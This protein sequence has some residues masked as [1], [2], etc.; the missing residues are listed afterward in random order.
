MPCQDDF[1]LSN[2][3]PSQDFV[4]IRKRLN[5][6]TRLLCYLC[7]EIEFAS[8]WSRYDRPALRKWWDRH[9]KRDEDCVM[10][11]MSAILKKRLVNNPKDLAKKFIDKA[12]AVHPVSRWH[13][14][15][16]MDMAKEACRI[17]ANEISKKKLKDDVV[18]KAL[19]KLSAEER[20]ALGTQWP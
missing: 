16:F 12:L 9:R 1:P 18:K 10:K 13:E 4:R 7:G 5:E 20:E 6:A 14:N 19:L 8:Q 15:W 3:G 11:K 17:R 2:E